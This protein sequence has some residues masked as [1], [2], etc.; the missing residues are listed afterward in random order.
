V[1]KLIYWRIE[2]ADVARCLR[3]LAASALGIPNSNFRYLES[4]FAPSAA[5]TKAGRRLQLLCAVFS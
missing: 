4:S 2:K 3:R 1:N 5:I